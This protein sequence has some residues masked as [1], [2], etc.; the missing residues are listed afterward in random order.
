MV[1]DDLEVARIDPVVLGEHHADVVVD[2]CVAALPVLQSRAL[3]G[4]L[5]AELDPL[6]AAV[7]ILDAGD[8]VAH[9]DALKAALDL[10]IVGPGSRSHDAIGCNARANVRALPSLTAMIVACARGIDGGP[11]DVSHRLVPRP[12]AR[13]LRRTLGLASLG[14]S[15][16]LAHRTR[17]I[18]DV[19]REAAARG[20]RQL[21]VLGAGLDARAHRLDELRD[22]IVFEVDQPSTQSYKRP[23]AKAL[24][25]RAKEIRY[26]AVD[27]EKDDLGER[28]A[29]AGHDRAS[30]TT[31][32]WEG[33]TMY[34]TREAVAGTLSTV[35]AR[36]TAGSELVLT[37]GSPGSIGS[38]AKPV[39]VAI[40][41]P[42]RWLVPPDV[43]HALA[44]EHGFE[45]ERESEPTT[46]AIA[47][48]VLVLR[49][50]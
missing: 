10:T 1:D 42:L 16:H 17:F 37:Y 29:S 46:R 36:S 11:D 32:I 44:R 14:L 38:L 40:R 31:W 9:R 25:V 7:I 35:R 43:M 4:H 45:V 39:F 34:L 20:V 2:P 47:E 15:S 33:V 28:L 26:V 12:L 24:D 21:V 6:G 13:V 19:V 3:I 5:L 22:T 50:Q 8:V 49:A 41:E 27:F 30:P 23:R 18:D 48:R